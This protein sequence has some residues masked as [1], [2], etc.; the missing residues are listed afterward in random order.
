MTKHFNMSTSGTRIVSLLIDLIARLE[1]KAAWLLELRSTSRRNSS[2][3]DR[4]RLRQ[5]YATDVPI[6]RP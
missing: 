1:N 4:R 5:Q 6:A 2:N 3:A